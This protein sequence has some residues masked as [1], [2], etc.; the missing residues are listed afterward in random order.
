MEER[1]SSYMI[2]NLATYKKH[3]EQG[4]DFRDTLMFKTIVTY[5]AGRAIF[6]SK[7]TGREYCM[8]LDAFTDLLR[9]NKLNNKEVTG[10]FRFVKKGQSQGFKLILSPEEIQELKDLKDTDYESL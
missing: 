7:S 1:A 9:L 2:R 8:F 4:D 6:K 5:S 3:L 10:E